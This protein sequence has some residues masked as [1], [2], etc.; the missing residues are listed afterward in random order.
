M[1]SFKALRIPDL[2]QRPVY[3]VA[4][5]GLLILTVL[6]SIGLLERS[7]AE[8]DR[9]VTTVETDGEL[10]ELLLALRR[11]ESNQR[12]Y[13]MTG[14]EAFFQNYQAA[15]PAVDRTLR[16][17]EDGLEQNPEQIRRV[18]A[19]RP[20]IAAKLKEMADTISLRKAGRQ[21][22]AID[23]LRTEA[24]VRY[25]NDIRDIVAQMRA[26]NTR[27]RIRQYSE[28]RTQEGWLFGANIAA[29]TLILLIAAGSVF[30]VQ[31]ANL[32]MQKAQRVLRD[33]NAQLE[34]S[35]AARTAELT[36]ANA[37]IQSF[38]YIVSHDLRSPLVNIMGFTSELETLKRALFEKHGAPEPSDASAGGGLPSAQGDAIPAKELEKDFD[39]ALG[40]IKASIT[41]MDRLINSILTISREGTRTLQADR[42]DL[43]EL[44]DT[45]LRAA[46]HQVLEAGAKINVAPLP[47][48]VSDRLALEQIFSNLV[49]N[50]LKY[51][52][53]D[54][55]GRIDINCTRRDGR[56]VIELQDNGRGIAERDKDRVFEL[57]R[58]AGNQD[59][60]GNGMGLAHV[61][62]L[63]RRLGGTIALD[64][65]FGKG[66]TFRVTLPMALPDQRIRT[67]T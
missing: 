57:F 46:A 61:R 11:V 39:E 32:A 47:T 40:F 14:E 53:D 18:E 9:L 36:A 17:V 7:R 3:L 1:I 44:F 27:Q 12:G 49:D 51:L 43:N 23:L 15:L 21:N 65:E 38:A 33:A 20:L 41:K 5:F 8:R 19:L 2:P 35:V 64:S 42:V 4:A 31:R 13:L 66:S 48:I 45:I 28:A 29:V 34:A 37:E 63:V 30:V 59:R 67:S 50:A 58:R 52:R 16:D 24:G 22:E 25:M 54:E 55:K 10:Y 26:E 60:P 62:A 56:I 6:I